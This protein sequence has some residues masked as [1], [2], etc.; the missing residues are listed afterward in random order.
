MIFLPKGRQLLHLATTLS[1]RHQKDSVPPQKQRCQEPE[2]STDVNSVTWGWIFCL[3]IVLPLFLFL[4]RNR[5]AEK[6]EGGSPGNIN[7]PSPAQKSRQGSNREGAGRSRP[8]GRNVARSDF[9]L[10][11]YG[12][13]SSKE[14]RESTQWLERLSRRHRETG[15]WE[16]L[17]DCKA[18]VSAKKDSRLPWRLSGQE[19]SNQCRRHGQISA[20]GRSHIP[21]HNY[22]TCALEPGGS[23]NDWSPLTLE[24]MLWL[25]CPCSE[26]EG[27]TMRSPHAATRE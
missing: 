13:L 6:Q 19:S 11:T 16:S 21:H 22:W 26:G 7:Q 1:P 9:L 15:W 3:S 27:T 25:S 17:S 20:P 10:P 18:H 8:P 24:S 5:K 2:A 14:T 23:H 12:L 4:S